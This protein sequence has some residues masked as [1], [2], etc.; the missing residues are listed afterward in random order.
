M[1]K[2]ITAP[3]EVRDQAIRRYGAGETSTKIAEDLGISES[4][5]RFWYSQGKKGE[6][7]A[8]ARTIQFGGHYSRGVPTE[9]VG[10]QTTTTTSE[11]CLEDVLKELLLQKDE[12]S[13]LDDELMELAVVV[14]NAKVF[15]ASIESVIAALTRHDDLEARA[16][17]LQ[18]QNLEI[19]KS[20]E[21]AM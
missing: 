1:P 18:A 5:V 17:R 8:T 3:A 21:A 10:T 2:G 9:S 16:S 19:L 4:I 15:I 6:A 13:E 14:S 11:K 7:I 20:L 12:I